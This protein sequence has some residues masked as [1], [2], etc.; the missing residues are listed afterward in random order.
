MNGQIPEKSKWPPTVDGTTDWEA[1]FESDEQGL[2]AIVLATKTPAQLKQI[3]ED[4]IRAL[5]SR[6]RDQPILGKVT[7]YLEKI[8]P[9][10]A[11]VERFPVMQASIKQLLDKIKEN[12]IERAAA[13]VEK[14][15]K[16][17]KRK[18]T[19][20]KKENNRR[21]NL[22]VGFFRSSAD[23][24]VFLFGLISRGSDK[25]DKDI[26]IKEDGEEA[27]FKQDAYVDQGGGGDTEWQDSDMYAM[28]EGKTAEPG[29][30]EDLEKKKKDDK[31]E[32]WDDYE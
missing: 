9:E 29:V 8:I 31:Y 6:K 20:N 2:F 18:K 28:K 17:A 24:F 5:F 3:S 15:A 23:A 11:D 22:I 32:S 25:K 26:A 1:L 13:Y 21:P 16:K 10:D 27:F 19:G 30:F 4:I 14:K 7:A 12:R